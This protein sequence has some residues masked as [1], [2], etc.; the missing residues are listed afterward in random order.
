M[1]ERPLFFVGLLGVFVSVGLSIL[2]SLSDAAISV[3]ALSFVYLALADR[4]RGAVGALR[5]AAFASAERGGAGEFNS[6]ASSS[7]AQTNAMHVARHPTPQSPRWRGGETATGSMEVT[8]QM[9]DLRIRL[10]SE[11]SSMS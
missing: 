7:P 1:P 9:I 10:A 5:L 11:L 8:N 3:G 2:P 4:A 6:K